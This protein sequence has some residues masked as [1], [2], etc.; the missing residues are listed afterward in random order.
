[1]SILVSPVKKRALYA[2]P[3]D[4]TQHLFQIAVPAA[5]NDKSY[6]VH[7]LR[8]SPVCCCSILLHMSRRLSMPRHVIGALNSSGRM[9]TARRTKR[10]LQRLKASWPVTSQSRGLQHKD[11]DHHPLQCLRILSLQRCTRLI[12]LNNQQSKTKTL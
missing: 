3:S 2:A 12:T 1:M 11:P 10:S 9:G 8:R 6:R 5:Q 7:L 4:T